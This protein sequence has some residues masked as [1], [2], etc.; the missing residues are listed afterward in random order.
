[1]DRYADRILGEMTLEEK[2]HQMSGDTWLWELIRVVT[3]DHWKYNDEPIPSGANVRLAIP[4]LLFSDGPRG[5]VVHHSTAFPVAMARGASWDRALERRFADAVGQELR[6]QGAN[7][8][9]GPCINL[10]RHPGWGRAQETFG[11]DPYLLGEMAAAT[12]GGVQRHNVMACAKHFALNSIDEPR[13]VI[14]VRADERTLREVYLPHFKRAVDAGVAV[15]MSSYNKVNGDYAAENEW[16]LRTVLKREWG[17]RG[18]VLSDF[19][20]GVYDG[21]K[22]ARAGLDVEM[23]LARQYGPAFLRDVEAGRVAKSLVDEAVRRILRRKISYLSRRDP[24]AYDASLVVSPDH[25]ALAREVAEKSMVLLK[26]EGALLPLDKASDRILAVLGRRAEADNLGD[27]G[28]SRV[29][30]PRVVTMLQGLRQYLGDA[31]VAFDAGTDLNHARQT[32]RDADAVVVVA[33][34]D[35]RD[36]GE[37]IPE[38]GMDERGGDRRSLALHLDEQQLILAAAA[39]NRRVVVVLVGGSAITMEEWKAHVPAVLMAWYP[40]MEGGHAL[41]RLLFGDVSPGKLT[42]TVPADPSWLPPFDPTAT[43]VEYGY[44]HGYTLVEKKGIEPAFPFGYGLTYT[45]FRYSGLHLS[46]PKITEDGAVDVSV[47]VSN[48]GSRPGEEVVELYAGF[49]HPAV[50]RPVKLLRGFE[51]VALAPGETQ[52]VRLVLKAADLSYY[53]VASHSWRVEPT[54]YTVLVG[55]SS[56]AADLLSAPLHVEVGRPDLH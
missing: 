7:L 3:L 19:V 21:L 27:H 29:Y 46:S 10:L 41:A 1:M 51:K 56:R 47:D 4:A 42:V 12:I 32:A 24:Q 20:R 2:V 39:E 40:G 45:R 25:V 8:F 11:E 16:L 53:D 15:I 5:A 50:D 22:A 28:S 52:T 23:P 34:L 31:R 37:W 48:V 35:F 14:D 38:K 54:D 9:G 18:I 17:F 49:P 55:G 33:G 6:A 13:N 30:P 43:S 44:Y 26:N 36:E